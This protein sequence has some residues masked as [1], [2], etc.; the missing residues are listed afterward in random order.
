MRLTEQDK[1]D[2]CGYIMDR[3]CKIYYGDDY[4]EKGVTFS[5]GRIPCTVRELIDLFIEWLKKR[6]K[7]QKEG[8]KNE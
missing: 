4:K 2:A 8:V 6:A 1:Q 3:A 5:L 7:E